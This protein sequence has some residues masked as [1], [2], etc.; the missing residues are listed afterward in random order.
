MK[1]FFPLPLS[2]LL[3]FLSPSY[4]FLP[5]PS[6]NNPNVRYRG[7]KGTGT[8]LGGMGGM[9]TFIIG[10]AIRKMREEEAK[11]KVRRGK[12]GRVRGSYI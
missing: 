1:S 8:E 11:K 2:I 5:S 9:P 6:L 3:L 10:G 4:S 12:G 7:G